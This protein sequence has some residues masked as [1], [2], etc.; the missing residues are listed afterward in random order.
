MLMVS[1][2]LFKVIVLRADDLGVQLLQANGAGD[3]D[4]AAQQEPRAVGQGFRLAM[5]CQLRPD[6]SH[7]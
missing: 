2:S 5:I 4:Q 1:P 6:V 3:F 7:G